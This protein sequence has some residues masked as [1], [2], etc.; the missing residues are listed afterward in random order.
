MAP[1]RHQRPSYCVLTQQ[2]VASPADDTFG[3]QAS[4]RRGKEEPAAQDVPALEETIRKSV[5]MSVE[6]RTSSMFAESSRALATV[7]A[8]TE[9]VTRE[10]SERLT[11]LAERMD[12]DLERRA[13]A[14]SASLTDTAAQNAR[15]DAFEAEMASFRGDVAGLRAALEDSEAERD[16]AIRGAHAAH[17]RADD[18]AAKL[19]DVRVRP[20]DE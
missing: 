20:L 15:M 3:V 19:T 1:T 5:L 14:E 17:I 10:V 13:R 12:A 16:A 9:G 2:R 6:L 8:R 11:S 18:L 4:A 7:Q